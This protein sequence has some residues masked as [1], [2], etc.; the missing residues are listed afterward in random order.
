MLSLKIK[1]LQ[2]I[3]ETTQLDRFL[4]ETFTMDEVMTM[5]QLN[6]SNLSVF[7]HFKDALNWR[8][9]C[10]TMTM[11]E[12]M[13][14]RFD[15]FL[16][17]PAVS[18]HQQLS[19]EFMEFYMNNLDVS[20]Q[21]LSFEFA[22]DH[23]TNFQLFFYWP[24]MKWTDA[25]F[26]AYMT[27]YAH[28]ICKRQFISEHYIRHNVNKVSWFGLS[29]AR[30]TWSDEFLADF[31]FQFD[32]SSLQT[33][34]LLTEAQIEL[35][36]TQNWFALSL[37]QV[38]S[39]EFITSHANH[40][41]WHRIACKQI[42]SDELIRRIQR[43][44]GWTDGLKIEFSAFLTDQAKIAQF[45]L[46]CHWPT[47]SAREDMTESILIENAAN[48]MWELV[49]IPNPSDVFLTLNSRRLSPRYITESAS[50]EFLL[51]NP[52]FITQYVQLNDRIISMSFFDRYFDLFG[53]AHLAADRRLSSHFIDKHWDKFNHYR[54]LCNQNLNERQRGRIRL[55]FRN[56]FDDE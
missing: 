37:N 47:L 52:Q 45:P 42:L 30:R 36:P 7:D 18:E 11:S 55:S 19:E 28:T 26:D 5:I 6:I 38:L 48:V 56:V 22:Q 15:R 9:I 33:C 31:F 21:Q 29:E 12:T 23:V 54:L 4:L 8:H 20:H 14:R 13:M 46:L 24:Q 32:T 51:A 34:A 40:V 43:M 41:I 10:Q 49:C 3:L 39:P 35:M 16:D 53:A 44:T 1:A 17:W 50:E 2:Q 27:D 25:H